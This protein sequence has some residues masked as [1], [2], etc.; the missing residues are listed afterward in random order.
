[1]KRVESVSDYLLFS[2]SAETVLKV[3]ETIRAFCRTEIGNGRKGLKRF[4]T[5]A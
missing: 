5:I 2:Q 1:M 3:F 4:R